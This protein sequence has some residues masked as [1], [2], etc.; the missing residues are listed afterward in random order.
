MNKRVQVMLLLLM[1]IACL[2]GLFFIS[3]AGQSR[4]LQSVE[5]VRTAMSRKQLVQDFA[6]VL[7][8]AESAQRGYILT[9]GKEYLA[10]Y[11][12]AE[13]EIASALDK[14]S[15]KYSRDDA[16][17]LEMLRDLRLQTGAK[18]AEMR[19]TIAL[20]DRGGLAPA[21]A[22]VQTD[23]GES[24]MTHVRTLI[25]T[26][27]G[28]EQ[29]TI[30]EAT[31]RWQ[32]EVQVARWL[33]G[34]GSATTVLLL[35]F[36][37]LLITRNLRKQETLNATLHEQTAQLQQTV[38]DRSA[39]LSDL[40]AN[41]QN[42]AEAEKSALARELHDELGG[43]LVGAKMDLSWLKK[44]HPSTDPELAARWDR[45]ERALEHGIDFKRR[46]VEQLRPTLLDNLGFNS[47]ARWIVEETC[48]SANLQ[49]SLEL[50][51]QEPPLSNEAA[52]ALF[53]VLQE[54]LTNVVK[55]SKARKVSVAVQIDLESNRI[56]L[57]VRD[58]GIGIPASRLQTL[59]GHGLGSMRHRMQAIGGQFTV[60][61]DPKGGTEIAALAA[62]RNEGAARAS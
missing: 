33:A 3:Y 27:I 46:I 26:L 39:E 19:T 25:A 6:S 15:E 47:A 21:L 4:I 14:V 32:H 36:A 48:A 55:H 40:A 50:S 23:E 16:A 52:I 60:R 62:L 12:A 59:G 9:G 22:V 45:L 31:E 58:D 57:I 20:Y 51:E 44:R 41:L 54:A 53:R 8:T 11:N 30:D 28:R 13:G 42:V 43:S 35:A 24:A 5:H 34:T 56:R 1:A 49:Y 38:D 61:S 17:T 10:P 18:L 37:A 29:G 2:C 7:V